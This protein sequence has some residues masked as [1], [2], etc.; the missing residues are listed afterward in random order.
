[1]CKGLLFINGIYS[2][3]C[4][5]YI[6][7]AVSCIHSFYLFKHIPDHTMISSHNN[8]ESKKPS[9]CRFIPKPVRLSEFYI[10]LIKS[11]PAKNL[12]YKILSVTMTTCARVW[13]TNCVVIFRHSY[14]LPITSLAGTSPIL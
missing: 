11:S 12:I 2:I 7:Y 8:H 6:F 5:Q 3:H 10:P 1:M 4:M 14:E 9:K 13:L